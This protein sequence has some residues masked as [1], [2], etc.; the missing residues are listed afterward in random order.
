[1][2]L[3]KHNQNSGPKINKET[4]NTELWAGVRNVL[5]FQLGVV[6]FGLIFGMLGISSGL[7]PLQTILMS[8]IIFGGASQ[9]VLVQLWATVTPPIFIGASVSMINM[10]HILY[11]ASVAP[12]LRQLPL[13]WRII[14]AYLLTDEAYAVSIKHFLEYPTNSFR[15]FYLLGAGMALWIF[16]QISTVVGVYTSATIPKELSLEFAIPLTFIAIITPIMRT[17]PDFVACVTSGIIALIGRDLPWNS[18]LLFAAI[19]GILA[20]WLLHSLRR[21][22]VIR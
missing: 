14:L 4:A 7:T 8:S 21:K 5:P 22:K 1:M 2:P 6:P 19:G 9:V 20:G 18:G 15:H 17:R 13:W 3:R 16:W 10:R 11:G 12:Y